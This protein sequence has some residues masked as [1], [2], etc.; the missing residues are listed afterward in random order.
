MKSVVDLFVV[1][2]R[3]AIFWFT[4]A[5]AS[6][7]ANVV[8]IHQMVATVAEKPQ[9]VIM[10]GAGNYY[11]APSV[12]FEHAGELHAAQTRLAVETLYSRGPEKLEYPH[13][14][15]R[16]FTPE[17]LGQIR[18]ELFSPDERPF[19]EQQ[20]HQTVEI[21][22][23]G[24]Y[25]DKIDP[26]GMAITHSKALLTRHSTFQGQEKTEVFEMEIYL[27]WRLNPDMARNGRF[28]TVCF[29]IKFADPVK[30]T[31]EAPVEPPD[32]NSNNN[33]NNP[34]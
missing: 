13:R 27:W 2:D 30:L 8:F 34:S 6:V 26:R 19:R 28:P 9:Y 10:D 23:A 17:A 3:T 11:V 22:E 1:K 15:E 24:V 16:L 33:S 32:N 20:I 5:C 12:E 21:L 25:K 7:V 14:L 4:V 29:Q 18:G 31:P